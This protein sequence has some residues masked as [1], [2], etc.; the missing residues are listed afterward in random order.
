MLQLHLKDNIDTLYWCKIFKAP[1]VIKKNH[2]VGVSI[3]LKFFFFYTYF[4]GRTNAKINNTIMF[5]LFCTA[6]FR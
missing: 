3:K 6:L 1:K 5:I 4:L 2:I